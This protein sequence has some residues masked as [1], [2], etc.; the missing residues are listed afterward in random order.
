MTEPTREACYV[1]DSHGRPGDGVSDFVKAIALG[2][3]FGAQF[4]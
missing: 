1:V 3:D 2:R 4:I